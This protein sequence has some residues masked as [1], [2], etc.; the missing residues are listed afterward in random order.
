VDESGVVG[1]SHQS[2][3]APEGV[4][5]DRGRLSQHLLEGT[6]LDERHREQPIASREHAESERRGDRDIRPVQRR[7]RAPLA[8]RRAASE[9]GLEPLPQRMAAAP[10]AELLDQEPRAARFGEMDQPPA[11]V[12]AEHGS[13]AAAPLPPAR[14]KHARRLAAS[15]PAGPP[16]HL[17]VEPK[18]RAHL[19]RPASRL[20]SPAAAAPSCSPDRV[21]ELRRALAKPATSSIFDDQAASPIQ[22]A[23][24]LAPLVTT[25]ISPPPP[26]GRRWRRSQRVGRI[27]V[28]GGVH[29]LETAA[30]AE[31]R[32][33][34]RRR[35]RRPGAL[36]GTARPCATTQSRAPWA[37]AREGAQAVSRP[38][39]WNPLPTRARPDPPRPIDWRT[40]LSPPHA[41]RDGKAPR[42]TLRDHDEAVRGKTVACD[43][44]VPTISELH[45]IIWLVAE[46]RALSMARSV[47]RASRRARRPRP[48]RPAP[49]N[50]RGCRP[51]A[52]DVLVSG[53]REGVDDVEASRG[54]AGAA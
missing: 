31:K 53:S 45:S 51:G 50:R 24:P 8:L 13:L 5:P 48:D 42:S 33:C 35:A 6:P 29:V 2:A 54:S 25:A 37:A 32:T 16:A 3:E 4:P 19:F 1:P 18:E 44:L 52:I 39:R 12:V 28:G 10:D 27:S 40:S 7:E 41:G 34:S 14:A 9:P 20:G 30:R 26:P 22:R 38:L 23:A 11:R 21:G 47:R 43:Q 17:L 36:P 15:A 46:H 49:C